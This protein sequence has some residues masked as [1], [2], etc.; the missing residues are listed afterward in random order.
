MN[1]PTFNLAQVAIHP[2]G[3]TTS[4]PSKAP[5]PSAPASSALRYSAGWEADEGGW[6]PPKA[7]GAPPR[8]VF[9]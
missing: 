2:T 7:A 8:L 9:P 4:T 6:I 3:T 1:D 5:W